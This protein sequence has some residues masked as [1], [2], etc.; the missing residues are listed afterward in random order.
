MPR[1]FDNISQKLLDALRSTLEAS[2]RADFCVGYL[3]LR[4]WQAIDD[5]I[6]G[7]NPEN[8]QICR[9]MVGMQRPPHDEIKALYSALGSDDAMD[10]AKAS[11]MRRKFAELLKEQITFGI[12]TG[13]DE[14]GLR[15][16]ARQLRAGHSDC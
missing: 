14:A 8:G 12:P 15:R 16:L 7:W 3:N 13:R 4:G 9:M 5:L 6:T 1:I 2:Q 10:N 11:Q